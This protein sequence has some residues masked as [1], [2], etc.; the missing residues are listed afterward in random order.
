MKALLPTDLP[1]PIPL[2]IISRSSGRVRVRVAQTHREPEIMAQIADAMTSF[3]AEIEQIRTN[4]STGSLTIC[5]DHDNGNLED[6]FV[7][8]QELGII[9][10]DVP[11]NTLS[12]E[13]SVFATTVTTTM[14]EL[15]QRVHQLT[16]GSIDLKSLVPSVLVIFA[17]RQLFAKGNSPIKIVPW[18]AL[19]WYAFDAFMK[20]NTSQ[21]EVPQTSN[22][23]HRRSQPTKLLPSSAIK[24][25]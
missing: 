25:K 5:Y 20:F 12:T 7:T 15:N 19:A 21:A 4:P 2:R 10:N 14:A 17:L 6:T 18:Y 13:N 22:N 11:A 24:Q 16:E 23:S 3:V 1:L 9:V 8:L